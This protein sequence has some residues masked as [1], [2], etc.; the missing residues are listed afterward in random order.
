[1]P[2]FVVD[3]KLVEVKGRRSIDALTAAKLAAVQRPI[4]LLLHADMQPI[5]EA[6]DHLQ[7]L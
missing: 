3:G 1:M 2:D 6:V 5:L 7:P 4:E